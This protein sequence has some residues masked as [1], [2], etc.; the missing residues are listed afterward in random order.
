MFSTISPHERCGSP[1]SRTQSESSAHKI[2]RLC[3]SDG[4]TKLFVG[5]YN[6]KPLCPEHFIGACYQ[7]L[8]SLTNDL[9]AAGN[10]EAARAR[11]RRELGQIADQVYAISLSSESLDR[12]AQVKLL[13][14]L[15]NA[16][17]ILG[18]I[19]RGDRVA[20]RVAIRLRAAAPGERW[21]E[22]T[23]TH[24]LSRHGATLH[25]SHLVLRGEMLTI[26]RLDTKKQARARVV[27][28]ARWATN[29]TELAVEIFSKGNFW[30]P[31]L[32]D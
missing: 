10:N 19:R 25:C 22:E 32:K 1:N 28:K 4:C 26:Q 23:D 30:A 7:K 8:D 17:Q 20:S 5:F 15:E 3:R 6:A 11:L 16:A 29:G 2:T 24:M 13:D 12:F 21:S 31:A 27:S 14:I 18:R 9:S